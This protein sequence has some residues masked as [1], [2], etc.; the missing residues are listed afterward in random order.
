VIWV[1]AQ[2]NAQIRILVFETSGLQLDMNDIMTSSIELAR[3][4]KAAWRV[5]IPDDCSIMQSPD[6]PGMWLLISSKVQCHFVAALQPS[7]RSLDFSSDRNIR[8]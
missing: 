8:S 1:E 4:N 6:V 7:S 5:Q 2:I 3:Q